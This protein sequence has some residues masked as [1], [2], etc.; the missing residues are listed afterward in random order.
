MC[1]SGCMGLWLFSPPGVEMPKSNIASLFACA[2][3]CAHVCGV[4]SFLV[5]DVV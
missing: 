3:T 5:N 1:E 4:F 2:H